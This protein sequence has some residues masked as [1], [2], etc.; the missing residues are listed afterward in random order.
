LKD[1]EYAKL[2]RGEFEE[3][4]KRPDGSVVVDDIE[5]DTVLAIPGSQWRISSHDAT[6][7]GSRLLSDVLLPG[8]KFPFP[9]SL[10]AVE[11][12]LRFFVKE[13]PD[14]VILDFFGGSGT[15]AHAVARLNRQDGGRR[16]SIVITNN[17]V[18]AEEAGLL[19]KNGHLPGDAEW[20]AQ[21]IFEYI[22]RPRIATAIT[23]LT[24]DGSPVKG[25][26]KFTDEFPMAD[27]FAENV[28]FLELLYLD[29]NVVSRSRAFESIAPLLWMKAGAQGVMISKEAPPFAAPP[30]ASYAIL[31]DVN[32]WPEFTSAIR[33]R[34]DLRQVFVITDSLAQFQQVASEL[35]TALEVSMLYEDYLRN[36]EISVGGAQ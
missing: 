16:R 36:F 30:N 27:G 26:Y 10:Y 18:S 19:R 13:K 29:R 2:T 17:E 25:D 12:T 21:G 7:Y 14:A 4:G 3:I 32:S 24:P 8:R 11:D 33:K 5:T 34:A 31:F 22:T 23:G 15:T 1:G 28:E 20:E 9:K 35:P 6:Q